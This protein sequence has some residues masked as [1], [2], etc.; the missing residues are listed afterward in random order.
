M[1]LKSYI[2]SP[3][4][5]HKFMDYTIEMGAKKVA[6]MACI[7]INDFARCETMNAEVI[8]AITVFGN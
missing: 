1:M 3:A 8:M 5:A 6:F 2:N 7:P 4:E